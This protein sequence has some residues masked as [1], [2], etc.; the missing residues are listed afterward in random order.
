M[1]ERLARSWELVKASASVLRSDKGL[2][3]FPFVSAIASLVVTVTFFVPAIF[4]AISQHLFTSTSQMSQQNTQINTQIHSPLGYLYIFLFYLTQYIVVFFANTAL[5]GAALV[6]LRGGRPTVG[7][8]FGLAWQHMRTILGYALLASTVGMVL[9]TLSERAGLLGRIGIGLVGMAWNVATYLV[10]PV[11]IMENVGPVE[12]V[13]RSTALLKRTWGEQVVGNAGLGAAF[14]VL[15]LLLF[16]IFIP[17]LIWAASLESFALIITVS[18]LFVIALSL[19]LLVQ[20][21][22]SGIYTAAVYLYA[23]EGF[24]GGPFSPEQIQAAFRPK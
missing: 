19:L 14:G 11:L 21:A 9:R 24:T 17:L 4:Y 2:L 8:G 13:K 7:T 22:L 23:S 15:L 16:L 18:V 6:R 3:I 1:S 12:A 20:S 10:A 5:I